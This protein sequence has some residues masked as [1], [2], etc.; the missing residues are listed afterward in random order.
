MDS[1][2]EPG[3][4]DGPT[5]IMVESYFERP[6]ILALLLETFLALNIWGL[7]KIKAN[8]SIEGTK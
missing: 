2:P 8:Q 4:A 5:A 3:G 6:R 1:L 7:M